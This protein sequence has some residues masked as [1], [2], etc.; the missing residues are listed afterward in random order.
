M[1]RKRALKQGTKKFPILGNIS[2]FP[3]NLLPK[4]DFH[5]SSPVGNQTDF[6]DSESG[7]VLAS[8]GV[9]DCGTSNLQAEVIFISVFFSIVM[10]L[11]VPINAE[12]CDF[13]FLFLQIDFIREAFPAE[14]R[15][16]ITLVLQSCDYDVE[17]A[18]ACFANGK[19]FGL[20][21]IPNS[22][23]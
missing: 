2:R 12:S 14:S 1:G 16:D 8:L 22:L 9:S 15:D 7:R 5:F 11:M 23:C 20:Q 6:F 18:I 4:D 19:S 13:S 21:K 3:R 17:A 10:N